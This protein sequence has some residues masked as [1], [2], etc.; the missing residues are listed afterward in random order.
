[1]K[2]TSR[3]LL[4]IIATMILTGCSLPMLR[5][6][7]VNPGKTP[8]NEPEFT[9]EQVVLSQGFQNTNPRV[10]LVRKNSQTKLIVSPGI[11]QS[12]GIEVS[13][14]EKIDDV[15]NI[16]LVNSSYSSA[17]LVIPQITILLSNVTQAE[18]GSLKFK[19]VNEN[20]TPISVSYGIVDVLKKVRSDYKISSDGYPSIKLVKDE[21]MT[22][23]VIDYES[24]YDKT[25][26]EIPLIN[27]RLKVNANTGEVVESTKSLI[28]AYVDHG[29]VLD[30]KPG[31]GI[32]YSLKDLE[33]ESNILRHQNLVTGEKTDLYRTFSQIS[34]ARL[35]QSG[36]AVALLEREGD[37]ASAFTIA[38]ENKKAIRIGSEAG[39][40]PESISWTSDTEIQILTSYSDNQ[41]KILTYNTADN[42]LTNTH[43]FMM[44]LVTFSV[45]EDVMLASQFTDKETNNRILLSDGRKGLQF[46]DI[47]F[48]PQILTEELGMHLVNQ[49]NTTE[50][51][52]H[53]FNL[54]TL[55]NEYELDFDV[56][57]ADRISQD[58]LL[59]VE[60]LPGNSSFGL[61]IFNF[62]TKEITSL[63]STKT[64]KIYLDRAT[65][66][67]YANDSLAYE[68]EAKDIIY[69][70]SLKNLKKR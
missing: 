14:I 37:N 41:T 30:F 61:H 9:V 6:S 1:M 33:N 7:S 70:L 25:N 35:N 52:L 43:S 16:Y 46:V 5:E 15:Y 36:S 45:M 3:L 44:D 66:T 39:I 32:L 48:R 23:W 65:D 58:E 27:L 13:K 19:I 31:A 26:L 64:S 69:A 51:R 29:T 54:K 21:E 49:D 53:L 38:L 22:I 8:E 47:G 57:K 10:E 63:G 40:R 24:I 12:T 55:E 42:I 18:A 20:Y 34:S 17:E 28:S 56:V 60:R 2:H 50:N 62:V 59:V 67:I 68:A 11:L 4:I